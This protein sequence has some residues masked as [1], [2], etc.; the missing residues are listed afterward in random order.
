MLTENKE[1]ISRHRVPK[2]APEISHLLFANALLFFCKANLIRGLKQILQVFENSLGQSINYDKSACLLPLDVGKLSWECCI[3]RHWIQGW[4][5]WEC[6]TG[7]QWFDTSYSDGNQTCYHGQER[8]VFLKPSQMWR[9][10]FQWT[11][12]DFPRMF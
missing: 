2:H 9:Q 12:F 7:F 11:I 6:H 3:W 4:N 5:I 10:T 8:L 1:I